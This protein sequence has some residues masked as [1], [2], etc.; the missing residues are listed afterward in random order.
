MKKKLFVI[1]V[2]L[3]TLSFSDVVEVRNGGDFVSKYKDKDDDEMKTKFPALDLG[4]EY[5]KEI[6][7]HV[8]AGGGLAFQYH[9]RVKSDEIGGFNSLPIYGTIRV[10]FYEKEK[11]K[12]YLKTELGYSYNSGSFDDDIYYGYGLGMQYNKITWDIMYKRNESK[13]ENAFEK[14]EKFYYD[15]ISFTSGYTFSF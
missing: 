14:K 10:N 5:R 7:K 3:G 12:G 2:F 9:K 4:L 8:E 11:M 13:F 6:I 15:R 1:L